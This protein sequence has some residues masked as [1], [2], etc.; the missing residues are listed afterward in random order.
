[1]V[2]GKPETGDCVVDGI[3][4]VGGIEVCVVVS[5]GDCAGGCAGG[6]AGDCDG[7]CVGDA[8]LTVGPEPAACHCELQNI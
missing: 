2:D 1:M 3:V 6:C 5:D 7:G 4:C 8:G